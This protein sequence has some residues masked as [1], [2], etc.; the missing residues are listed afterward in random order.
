MG[1]LARIASTALLLDLW[2]QRGVMNLAALS[3]LLIHTACVLPGCLVDFQHTDDSL[4]GC[5]ALL[6]ESNLHPR[7]KSTH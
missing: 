1:T 6:D 2:L 5:G 7:R 3:F 4:H